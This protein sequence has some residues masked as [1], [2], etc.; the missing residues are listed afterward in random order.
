MGKK[1]TQ[2]IILDAADRVLE[3]NNLANTTIE[4]VAAEAGMSK[5][6]VLHYFST[7]RALLSASLRRFEERYYALREEILENLPD[8]PC[9]LARATMSAVLET[10]RIS[11]RA[12]HYRIDMIEDP[13]YR[14][15]IGD[16]KMRLCSDMLTRARY[17]E[18]VLL[19]LYLM[20]G[21]WMNA[22]FSP[23]PIPKRMEERTREWLAE[24]LQTIYD[25]YE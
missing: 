4:A 18:K 16:M 11:G 9:R 24:Y 15:Q 12:S 21:L 19:A 6:G 3:S 20:D 2:D 13:E 1:K 23:R 5:G 25:D 8:T 10:R 14:D 22:L 7:K 17:P